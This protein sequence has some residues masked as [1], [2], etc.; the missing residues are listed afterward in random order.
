[1]LME[2]VEL[3]L[4]AFRGKELN[5]VIETDILAAT[6]CLPIHS[7]NVGLNLQWQD[8]SFMPDNIANRFSQASFRHALV[9]RVLSKH[10]L[11]E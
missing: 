8:D 2:S 11:M 5:R 1:M 10:R 9:L 3:G 4:N 6:L 7:T